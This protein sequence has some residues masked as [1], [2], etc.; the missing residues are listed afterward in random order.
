MIQGLWVGAL[1]SDS[2][3]LCMHGLYK[4]LGLA[5]CRVTRKSMPCSCS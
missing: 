4:H 5:A 3:S 2:S 1:C